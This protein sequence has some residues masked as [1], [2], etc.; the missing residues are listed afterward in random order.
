[1]LRAAARSAEDGGDYR[2]ALRLVR[3]LPEDDEVARWRRQLEEVLR[4][5]NAAPQRATWLVHPAVRWALER[6]AGEILERYARLL[7]VTLGVL[8]AER[9]S[10]LPLVAAS[11]EVVLDAGLFDAG[12]FARYLEEGLSPARRSPRGPMADWGVQPPS[13]FR[14]EQA[15]GPVVMLSE[16][17]TQRQVRCLSWPS[18]AR[19]PAGTLMFG[20]LLLVGGPVGRAFALPPIRV[21]Q[22][23]A[24]RLGRTLQRGEGPEERLRAVARF[25]RRDQQERSAA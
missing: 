12:L 6:A 18:A 19:I 20:R 22:R 9:Q 2:G 25:R 16:L 4:L 17:S 1:V 11:D 23:C 8:G 10:L 21:D 24:V 5:P 14:L 15:Q 7:L 13:V 3:Q